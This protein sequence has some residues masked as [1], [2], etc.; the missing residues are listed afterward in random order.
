M[1]KTVLSLIVPFVMA[2]AAHAASPAAELRGLLRSVV[3]D[4]CF[5]FGQHDATAYGRGW[6]YEPG[7]SDIHDVTGDN[8]GI[9]SW[10]IAGVELGSGDNIDKVPHSFIRDQIIKQHQ[11]GG[12]STVSWHAWNP[13]TGG[14]SWD[15]VGRPVDRIFS[16]K[17]LRRVMEARIDSVARFISSLRDSSGR[18]IPVLFRP[19]FEMNGRWFWWGRGHRSDANY[20]KLWKLTYDRFR[21]AGLKDAVLWCYAPN[22]V[23]ADNELADT[24]PGDRMVDVIGVDVYQSG[25]D[26][27]GYRKALDHS[28]R[29]ISR[30]AAAHGKLVALAETGSEGL[31]N[32]G[33]WDTVV[34]PVVRR[35][36]V[37]WV[38]AWRNSAPD[39]APFFVP[40]KGHP[41]EESFRNFYRPPAALFLNDLRRRIPAVSESR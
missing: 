31:P 6:R 2:C 12:I 36:P 20:R 13:V 30:F 23:W 35:Y 15:T 16:D 28:L 10:D 22:I 26:V 27:A 39:N 8:P 4:S 18:Q 29:R 32:S 37:A 21:K 14:N 11:R 7:R 38:V 9:M 19:W 41:Q 3:A 33:W 5:V 24:Y 34:L 25:D 17:A 40:Y 1:K